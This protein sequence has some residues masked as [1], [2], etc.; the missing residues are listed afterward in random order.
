MNEHD[1]QSMNTSD[2]LWMTPTLLSWIIPAVL[3]VYLVGTSVGGDAVSG[4]DRWRHRARFLCRA[5]GMTIV[6]M[7]GMVGLATT[8]TW[9]EQTELSAFAMA[10]G[11]ALPMLAVMGYRGHAWQ[12]S[13]E[14]AAAVFLPA[15]VLLV[16][17]W[18]GVVAPH[19]VTPLQML[20]MLPAMLGVMLYRAEQYTLE[21]CTV[22][23]SGR[24]GRLLDG[25]GRKGGHR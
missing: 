9:Y 7:L 2:W 12:R 22:G 10:S 11:M 19:L 6:M 18:L 17:F 3:A 1:M 15:L 4:S 5:S 20:V 16:L 8:F 13:G 21:E 25:D 23:P 24:L 14:M